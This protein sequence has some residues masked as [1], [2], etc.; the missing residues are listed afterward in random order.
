MVFALWLLFAPADW[1]LLVP[2]VAHQVLRVQMQGTD[3]SGICSAVVFDIDKE[4]TAYALTAAHCVDHQP[5]EH[6]DLT[7]DERNATTR[8][9]NRIL[10]FF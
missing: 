5:T 2:T 10:D 9:F 8:L 7:V 1:S 4:G 3:H 6:F